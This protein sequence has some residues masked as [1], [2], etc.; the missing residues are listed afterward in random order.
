MIFHATR[1]VVGHEALE[2]EWYIVIKGYKFKIF[3]NIWY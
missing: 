3:E 1:C 2:N